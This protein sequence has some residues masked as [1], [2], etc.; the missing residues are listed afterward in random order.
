MGKLRYSESLRPQDYPTT[1]AVAERPDRGDRHDAVPGDDITPAF[2][3]CAEKLDLFG[4][5]KLCG[6]IQDKFK[7]WI[8][9]SRTKSTVKI[10][11][12][13]MRWLLQNQKYLI[14]RHLNKH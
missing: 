1:P 12:L 8:E 14:F 9:V 10:V 3:H 7:V 4:K 6:E 13:L 11:G 2:S 5:S